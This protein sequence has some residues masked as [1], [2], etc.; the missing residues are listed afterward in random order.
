MITIPL[1][2]GQV[3]LI[4]D[5]DLTLVEHH[6]WHA[7]PRRD[8]RGYYAVNAS[9]IR[10]HRLLLGVW[11]KRIVDHRD[12]NGL[13][14]RRPNLRVGSQSL[15]CVNR[16]TTPGKHLR[17]VD[18]RNRQWRARIKVGGKMRLIGTFATERE[19]HE[20]F[21]SES[22]RL[23]GDWQPLP[24]PLPPPPLDLHEEGKR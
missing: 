10:M 24:R 15:N 18:P 22:H 7:R 1:T 6:S 23:H 17:G 12:G 21:L 14:N 8:G 9:G 20:A 3:A 19:A 11:D 16:K 5:A 4:D 2:L 13:D